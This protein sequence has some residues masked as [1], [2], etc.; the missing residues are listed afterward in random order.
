MYYNNIET[1][2]E[3]SRISN[4]KLYWKLVKEEFKNVSDKSIPPLAYTDEQENSNTAYSDHEKTEVL[5]SYF[6]SISDLDDR[7]VEFLLFQKYVT[8]LLGIS[9]S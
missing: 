9:I 3:Q 5:N 8:I 2:V 7:D 6:V 4:P 1:F